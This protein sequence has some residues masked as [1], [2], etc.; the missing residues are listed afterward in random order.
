MFN[1]RIWKLFQSFLR[2][3]QKLL[4]THWRSLLLLLVGIYLPLQ[5]FGEL[6]EE[7]WENEGGFPWDVPI[8]LAIHT[9][10]NPQLNFLAVMLTKLGVLGR[11]SDCY[12]RR[13]GAIH[14]PEV[15]IAHLSGYYGR[16]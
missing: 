1:A 10:A 5:V 4:V 16:I 7:V 3:L 11:V 15:A 12:C 14:P 13:V 9:R 6:A 2:F 8:L